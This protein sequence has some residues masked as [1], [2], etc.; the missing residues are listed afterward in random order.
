MNWIAASARGRFH[1]G[2]VAAA[3][4]FLILLAAAGTRA[5]PSV[6]MVPLGNEFGWSR[7]TVSLA[8]SINIALYG[9][10]GPF[11]AA[12]MQ[13]FGLRPTILTALVVMGTG[14]ALS[15][16]MTATWQMVLIWGVM[17]GSA[18]GVAALT[19]SATFVNRWFVAR[20][21]LVMGMLTASSATGQMVFL[22]MLASISEHHGWRP[23]VLVVA[24][25]LAIVV[26]LVI[27]L[28]PERPADVQLRPYGEPED[29]PRAAEAAKQNPL[30]TA[31]E[32]LFSAARRRD[33]W[34]LFFSF[35]IC[36]ASTNGYIG[37]HLIAM[38]SDY[39]M[40]EVQGA[41]LLAA[42]GIFDLIGTTAS[43]WL[44]DRYDSRV[45]L[46]WYY[47]LRG[48]SLIYLPHAFGIDFFGLPLFAV[49]YGLDWIATVPPT[50]RLAT[51]IW[52][53]ERAPIVFGW[54]VAGH[55]LG[56]AFATLGAG[57]LR[58]SLGTYTLASMIS[59]GLCIVGALIVLRIGR[60][61][62]RSVPQAA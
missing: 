6:L 61:R 12:A 20:R 10:T 44:S 24:V 57:L 60:G 15:S 33:F 11:A 25:A 19:L 47:G 50:V 53:K 41:S 29:A 49:F 35:F 51:D 39:G 17:V 40:S 26:P 45:L 1:Y 7:A 36:G 28:L 32:A 37:S 21:G 9:L 22:P 58:A 52:G 62:T 8:I 46:F 59:G 55:Q 48:L 30:A 2:W 5:T 4:V 31:F 18:T 16:M 3:V 23:V 27:F 42:M 38:C 43:G 13:R 56:A 14:V 54:I 34:L